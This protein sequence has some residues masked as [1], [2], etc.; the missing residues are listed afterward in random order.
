MPP[1]YSKET[2]A[3]RRETLCPVSYSKSVTAL[4]L[5]PSSPG[6]MQGPGASPAWS[7]PPTQEAVLPPRVCSGQKLGRKSPRW[8]GR[9]AVVQSRQCYQLKV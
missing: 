4:S 6:P 1:F 5:E 8:G 3:L 7:W 9:E 2:K